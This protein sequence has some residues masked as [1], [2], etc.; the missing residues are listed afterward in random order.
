MQRTEPTTIQPGETAPVTESDLLVSVLSEQIAASERQTEAIGA[1][2]RLVSKGDSAAALA[3][4]DAAQAARDA[5]QA[6]RSAEAA[7]R[8]FA[9]QSGNRAFAEKENAKQM[10]KLQQS[11]SLVVGELRGALRRL[12]PLELEVSYQRELRLAAAGSTHDA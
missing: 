2:A 7:V 11:V 8:A 6:A 1:L 3:A 5:A 9:E 10:E 12:G 4:S